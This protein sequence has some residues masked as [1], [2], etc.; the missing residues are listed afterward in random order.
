MKYADRELRDIFRHPF[1]MDA[2]TGIMTRLFHARDVRA[3]PERLDSTPADTEGYYLGSMSTE[4]HYDIGFFYY[5]V[6]GNVKRKRVGL[7]RL[8]RSFTNPKWG[9]F[10]AALAVFESGGDWRLS[11]VSDIRGEETAP[12]RYTYVFGDPA[13]AYNTPVSRFVSLQRN[14]VSFRNLMKAFS[15]EALTQEF[16]KDLFQWY[17]WAIREDSGVSFPGNTATE[18]DDRENLSVKVIRLI[19]RLLF[20]WFI[21]QKDLVPGRLF[22]ATYIERILKD[23]DPRSAT[24]GCYY[25]AIL[26][27]LFFA[28][29]NRAIRDDDG[30]PRRFAHV[31]GRDAKTLYRYAE[32]FSISED[33]V[34]RLFSD[35]PF[36]NGGLFDCLDKDVT[37]D[38][39]ERAY[40]YDGF[41]R[42]DARFADGRYKYRAVVPNRLFFDNKDGLLSILGRYNFTVEEN[43]LSERQVALDPEL[44]GKVFENLLGAYNPETRETARKQTGSFYTPREIVSFMVDESL[45]AYLGASDTV[46]RLFSDDFVKEEGHEEEYRQIAA[47]LQQIKVLDP[48]CGSGAFPMGMLTRIT[49]LLQKLQPEADTYKLKLRLIEQCLYGSDT[50]CIAAQITKLRF[51]ISLICDCEKDVRKPN[52]GMPTLP[53]LETKF[54]A[55]DTLV[56]IKR[57]TQHNLFENP[58]IDATK[59]ELAAVRHDYFSAKTAGAKVRLRKRDE[60]LRQRLVSL[61]ASGGDFAPDDAHQIA[62][63]NPYDQNASSP[64]FDPEWMFGVSQGFDIVIGNPPYIQLQNNGGALAEKYSACGYGTFDRTGDIYCLFYERGVQMLK[65]RGHLCFITS[66]KWMRAGYGERTRRFFAERTDPIKLIDFAGVGVFESATVDVNILLLAKDK[67]RHSTVCALTSRDNAQAVR[68]NLRAFVERHHSVCNFASS[69]AWTILSPIEKSIRRKIEEA[70][71]PLKDWDVQIYRGILTGCNEA[72]IITTDKRNEILARCAGDD[73]RRRTERLIRPIL[74]GKDI[75][76]YGYNWAGTWLINTHNGVKGKNGNIPRIKIEDYPAVKAHLDKYWDRIHKRLDQ[77]DTPYN[78]RNC[79]YLQDFEKPKIVWASV[80][81]LYYSLIPPKYALLDTMYFFPIKD[82]SLFII[83]LLN[84][85][86][87]RHWIA[88]TDTPIGNGGAYRHYKYNIEKLPIPLLTGDM[89]AKMN[90][91]VHQLTDS[92]ATRDNIAETDIENQIDRIVYSLYNLS[93]EEVDY[94]EGCMKEAHFSVE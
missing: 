35:V 88:N 55:A 83:A 7:R 72:F 13:G 40:N 81:G 78:L 91:F 15:V 51:F 2:W 4:D 85:K 22:D 25:N 31:K 19:T 34:V 61:L 84:S 45:T 49:E 47:R 38:G 6:A 33:D 68:N 64:F 12:K 87:V 73:E 60:E 24:D 1:S 29:L 90:Y 71:T 50:Q 82:N 28:T 14:G 65:P 9:L 21:K 10:D 42:N 94:I 36:L 52:F 11:L 27:N 16:Y 58:Q 67:N 32:L 80:G 3:V 17:Q 18:D 41:S 92:V 79:A 63:W 93:P 26:Q 43:S 44:L 70:G 20:V 59:R 30:Q 89:Q 8:V 75:K 62:A 76:R 56:S 48:A 86:L 69:D 46:K 74:R 39:V 66:N 37:H 77:G 53:N 23:F 57:R 5:R 54:V